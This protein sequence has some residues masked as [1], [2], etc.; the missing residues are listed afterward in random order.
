M[1]LHP[2]YMDEKFRPDGRQG[3]KS[4]AKIKS[5]IISQQETYVED[6]RVQ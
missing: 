4:W 3:A 6:H 5:E 2:V 1:F